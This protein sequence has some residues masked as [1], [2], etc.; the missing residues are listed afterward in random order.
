MLPEYRGEAVRLVGIGDRAA[1]EFAKVFDL[2]DTAPRN[3]TSLT[4]I[5]T[6][7]GPPVMLTMME[8]EELVRLQRDNK[9][10]EMERKILKN[11]TETC[12]ASCVDRA[13]KSAART[14]YRRRG[15]RTMGARTPDRR[16]TSY[17]V[18]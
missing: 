5:G 17:A 16:S 4:A 15:Y 8:R 6:D 1:G 9:P 3:W 14:G 10:L 11:E 13:A 2:P 12:P 7:Q 18:D